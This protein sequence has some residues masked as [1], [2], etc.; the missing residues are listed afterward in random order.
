[1]FISITKNKYFEIRFMHT[2]IRFIDTIG[3]LSAS[4]STLDKHIRNVVENT[5]ILFK[6]EE[7]F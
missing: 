2:L 7:E 1:M 6:D 5:S 3:F 4:L